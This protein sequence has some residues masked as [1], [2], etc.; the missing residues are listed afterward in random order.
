MAV[1]GC[2]ART[3]GWSI[4]PYTAPANAC[5]LRGMLSGLTMSGD[6]Q[7]VYLGDVRGVHPRDGAGVG[8]ADRAAAA[9]VGWPPERCQCGVRGDGRR[10]APPRR[11]QLGPDGAGVGPA[12]RQLRGNRAYPSHASGRGQHSRLARNGHGRWHPRDRAGRH[13]MTPV[14]PRVCRPERKV[15]DNMVGNATGHAVGRTACRLVDAV[16]DNLCSVSMHSPGD[17]S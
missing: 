9:G 12:Y 10:L 15:R 17:N 3:G 13:R 8:S 7:D 2:S 14:G 1:G 16:S 6:I 4:R 11:R 5:H